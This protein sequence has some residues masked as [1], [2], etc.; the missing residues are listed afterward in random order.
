MRAPGAPITA[1]V[2]TDLLQSI[3]ESIR[4]SGGSPALATLAEALAAQGA[5]RGAGVAVGA[6]ALQALMA[7]VERLAAP[8]RTAPAPA[9]PQPPAGRAAAEPYRVQ[10]TLSTAAAIE[11]AYGRTAPSLRASPVASGALAAASVTPQAPAAS[12]SAASSMPAAPPTQTPASPSGV[13]VDLLQAVAAALRASG[14]N[15]ALAA[16]IEDIVAQAG[17]RTSEAAP[18]VAPEMARL[19]LTEIEQAAGRALAEAGSAPEVRLSA[20]LYQG[21]IAALAIASEGRPTASAS[22]LSSS[23]SSP[24]TAEAVGRAATAIGELV[25]ELAAGAPENGGEPA[26]EAALIRNALNAVARLQPALAQQAALALTV[27]ARIAPTDPRLGLAQAVEFLNR[28]A[29]SVAA[30]PASALSPRPSELSL[31]APLQVE[32]EA[33][34]GAAPRIRTLVAELRSLG[35]HVDAQPAEGRPGVG[36]LRITLGA[37]EPGPP[38]VLDL[39]PAAL[40]PLGAEEAIRSLMAAIAPQAS[41]AP[42]LPRETQTTETFL[43]SL[44]DADPQLARPLAIALQAAAAAASPPELRAALGR[45]NAVLA[46]VLLAIRPAPSSPQDARSASRT[47]AGAFIIQVLL[48]ADPARTASME[49]AFRQLR[50]L[51]VEVAVREAAGPQG[52]TEIAIAIHQTGESGSREAPRAF[53]MDL[54]ST[55][56]APMGSPDDAGRPALAHAPAERRLEAP[57]PPPPHDQPGQS[58]RGSQERERPPFH[59]TSGGEAT[60]RSDEA[61]RDRPPIA[62]VPDGRQ[63]DFNPLAAPPPFRAPASGGARAADQ[64]APEAP[65]DR[66]LLAYEPEKTLAWQI[67]HFREKSPARSVVRVRRGAFFEA[68]LEEAPGERV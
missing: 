9:L 59:S 11:R 8:Q 61:S 66:L 36:V 10:N 38:A 56:L 17:P 4:A 57:P 58:G 19:I 26:A 27:Y 1:T 60:R 23:S 48:N 67:A 44:M 41:R 46:Q 49:D 53:S 6:N 18:P 40:A 51:G 22:A 31:A 37:N 39:R 16:A 12:A 42:G 30:E 7:E 54:R 15:P 35:A 64:P 5:D 52:K 34:I 2:S 28:L 55:A 33:A 29:E 62:S 3:A 50:A 25:R 24:P 63:I 43:R 47:P 45:A 21:A 14:G 20:A 13:S 65:P 32:L 68:A